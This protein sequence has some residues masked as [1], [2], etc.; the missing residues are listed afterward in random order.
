LE[1]VPGL[2]LISAIVML[3]WVVG[4]AC[5]EYGG[6]PLGR[7]L[8]GI[9]VFAEAADIAEASSQCRSGIALFSC[10]LVNV[11]KDKPRSLG[12]SPMEIYASAPRACVQPMDSSRSRQTTH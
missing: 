4:R 2:D 12:Q 10:V 5:L 1:K 11:K 9:W 6:L 8:F 7:A 3:R